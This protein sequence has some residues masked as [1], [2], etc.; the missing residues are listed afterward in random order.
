MFDAENKCSAHVNLTPSN[1]R[2]SRIKLAA[3]CMVSFL[4]LQLGIWFLFD[5]SFPLVRDLIGTQ[6]AAIVWS[7]IVFEILK[8]KS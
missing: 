7:T 2:R 1:I 6:L 4:I 8:R 5:D 3:Y